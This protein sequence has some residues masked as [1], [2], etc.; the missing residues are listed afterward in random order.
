M[1]KRKDSIT[2][3]TSEWMRL[4]D[5]VI[6]GNSVVIKCKD[7]QNAKATRLRFYKLRKLMRNSVE[8]GSADYATTSRLA[9][10]ILVTVPKEGAENDNHITFIERSKDA[11]SKL[12]QAAIP[13]QEIAL[14]SEPSFSY[15]AILEGR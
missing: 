4:I 6:A 5:Y 15:E 10:D 14:P 7:N 12:I 3:Y 1:K 2:L 8:S 13:E 11:D 9:D